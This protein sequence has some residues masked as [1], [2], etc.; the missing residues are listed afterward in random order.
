MLNWIVILLHMVRWNLLAESGLEA[1]TRLRDSLSQLRGV[2]VSIPAILL[3]WRKFS[4]KYLTVSDVRCRNLWFSTVERPSLGRHETWNSSSLGTDPG[5]KICIILQS[6]H[7]GLS[8]LPMFVT[9]K[10]FSPWDLERN[11]V[12]LVKLILDSLNTFRFSNGTSFCMSGW[13][14]SVLNISL[15]GF[16]MWSISRLGHG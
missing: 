16:S 10:V 4:V 6:V 5:G 11:W 2:H 3:R 9:L 13:L 14:A 1:R 15:V 7:L 8:L 12:K